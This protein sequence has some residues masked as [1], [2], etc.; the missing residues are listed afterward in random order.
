MTAPTKQF[1]EGDLVRIATG[2]GQRVYRIQSKTV[3]HVH[4]TD[5]DPRY[6]LAADADHPDA[7]KRVPDAF[8]WY[9][10]DELTGVDA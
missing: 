7:A 1:K 8:R 5:L 6:Y 9:R 2:R 4:A 3:G 10:A